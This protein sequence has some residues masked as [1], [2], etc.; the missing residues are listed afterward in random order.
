MARCVAIDRKYPAGPGHI[1]FVPSRAVQSSVNTAFDTPV[2][3]RTNL[4]SYIGKPEDGLRDRM[5]LEGVS[6]LLVSIPSGTDL[7]ENSPIF[8]TLVNNP[9]CRPAHQW[10][11]FLQ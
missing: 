7:G 10:G 9:L 8:D 6:H 3:V 5:K 2:V 1:C 11:V 4:K